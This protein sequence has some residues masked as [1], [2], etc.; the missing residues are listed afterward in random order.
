MKMVK[1]VRQVAYHRNGVSGEPFYVVR[2][3]GMAGEEHVAILFSEEKQC[4][5]LDVNKAVDTI[6]F[7]ENSWRG[8]N[9]E[10]ELRAAIRKYEK[11]ITKEMGLKSP[12][13]G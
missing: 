4:A 6:R 5:V 1:K 11:K 2:F 8:D 9:Y 13:G 12:E 3:V 10:P 7:M